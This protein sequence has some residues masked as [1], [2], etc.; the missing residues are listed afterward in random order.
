MKKF[1]KKLLIITSISLSSAIIG[2][3][4]AT[5]ITSCSNDHQS[6]QINQNINVKKDDKE[7]HDKTINELKLEIIKLKQEI[8]KLKQERDNWK[9]NF[10]TT[11]ETLDATD[12]SFDEFEDEHDKL[13]S[14]YNDLKH[15]YETLKQE[16]NHH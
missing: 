13:V 1:N 9:F 7:S 10:L 11:K 14:Q 15:K 4:L 16:L 5:N 3:T 6:K 12:K 2:I 8:T